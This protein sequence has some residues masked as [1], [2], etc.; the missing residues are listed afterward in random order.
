ME[1]V[2]YWQ[3]PVW[4]CVCVHVFSRKHLFL[5]RR[6]GDA[7]W[8]RWT[9]PG[10]IALLKDQS[11]DCSSAPPLT[12]LFLTLMLLPFQ[13]AT[14]VAVSCRYLRSPVR[15]SFGERSRTL[16]ELTLK[17]CQKINKIKNRRAKIDARDIGCLPADSQLW[18]VE[19]SL[20]A[21]KTKSPPTDAKLE[22]YQFFFLNA[23]NLFLNGSKVKNKSHN[24]Q[25]NCT[26]KFSFFFFSLR[27]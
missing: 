26:I 1:N 4:E 5:G 27:S 25:P 22:K 7:A 8:H 3:R 21:T 12:C 2:T 11:A 24:F 17:R 9:S 20:N 10:L 13:E 6:T 16:P 18:D 19:V 15:V 14:G 23:S